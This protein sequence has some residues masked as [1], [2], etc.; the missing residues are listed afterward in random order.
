MRYLIVLAVLLSFAAPAKAITVINIHDCGA[1]LT[2]REKDD[3]HAWQ[4][5]QA[6]AGFLSGLAVG[7]NEEF[8]DLGNGIT[9]VQVYYWMDNYCREKSFK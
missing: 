5:Q 1:W 8:W 6:L 7:S 2:V 9:P 3:A 4:L